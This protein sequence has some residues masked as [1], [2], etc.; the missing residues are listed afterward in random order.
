MFSP[1]GRWIAYY[2]NPADASTV[3]TNRGIYIEPFPP[4]GQRYQVPKQQID[5]QP[6]WSPDGSE[7]I[8][9]PSAASGQLA[10]V[11]VM[12]RSGLT[13][14]P[15]QTFPAKTTVGR[16]SSQPRAFDILPNGQFVGPISTEDAN[17]TADSAQAIRVVL[18]WFDEL[19]SRVPTQK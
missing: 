16:I 10:A 6:V 14:G 3:S 8:Y 7:L 5:F 15:T 12:F 17:T 1:D 2:S 13:F 9:V 11:R 4:T 19:K 18:N